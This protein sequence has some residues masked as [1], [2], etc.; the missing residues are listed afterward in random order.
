[1]SRVEVA[2]A[3]GIVVLVAGLL[4]PAIARIQETKLQ[5]QCRNNLK[6]QGFA[7]GNYLDT[8]NRLPPLVDQ[9][10]GAS[11]GEWLYSIY[12]E[13]FPYL[14]GGVAPMYRRGDS[15]TYHGH[16]S[17]QF[18]FTHKDRNGWIRHGGSANQVVR[19]FIDPADWTAEHIQD[20]PMTLPD[21][22][23]GYY[24]AG[25]YAFN[26]LLDWGKDDVNPFGASGSSNIILIVEKPQICRDAS[27]AEIHN[28]WGLGFYSPNMPAFAVLTPSEPAGLLSTGQSAPVTPL[29]GEDATDRNTLIRVRIGRAD[30]VSQPAEFP[31]PV[32]LIEKARACD[33]RLPGTPHRAGMQAAM[34]DGSVR[35][36]SL[37]V[38]PW[39]FWSECVP[40]RP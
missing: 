23:T 14:E 30:A 34:G 8:F 22:S 39:V 24:A 9:G 26:G 1:M 38:E 5:S 27:G 29:P 21:G 28:L 11:T 3:L 17:M 36:Y 31:A 2:I 6:Q 16:S 4:L 35:L 33:P 18:Q 37:D 13:L 12:A 32:Q 19:C 15:T 25:S 10:N 7:I 20:V 40:L